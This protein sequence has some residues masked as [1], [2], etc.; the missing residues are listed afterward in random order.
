MNS[1]S[2]LPA[3]DTAT[4]CD[5]TNQPQ[6]KAMPRPLKNTSRYDALK[7]VINEIS[8]SDTARA[9]EALSELIDAV[10]SYQASKLIVTED[11]RAAD[12]RA[13]DSRRQL[14]LV[15]DSLD[16]ALQILTSLEP[17]ALQALC[18]AAD[19][20]LGAITPPITQISTWARTAAGAI[21]VAPGRA[22]TDQA[23]ALAYTVSGV[24]STV[25]RLPVTTTRVDENITGARNGAAFE[26][27]LKVTFEAAG[28]VVTDLRPYVKAAV[29]RD[30]MRGEA[31][32][33]P[34][35][36]S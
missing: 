20:T 31:S 10:E 36:R 28:I 7:A 8:P 3:T 19:Q 21:P 14:E 17:A 9:A 4:I 26:R 24:M 1:C 6:E 35:P 11:G 5:F 29:K 23:R 32:G 18:N 30:A 12:P 34:S 22:K 13:V 2:L 15:A 27:L 25:L 16:Q 33:E